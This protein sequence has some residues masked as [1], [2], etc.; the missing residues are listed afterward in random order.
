[1]TATSTSLLFIWVYRDPWTLAEKRRGGGGGGAASDMNGEEICS[2]NDFHLFYIHTFNWSHSF[3]SAAVGYCQAQVPFGLCPHRKHALWLVPWQKTCPLACALTENMPFGLCPDRKHA[4][5][6]VPWQ[7]TCPLAWALTENMPFG[8]GPDRKQ[9]VFC[10]CLGLWHNQPWRHQKGWLELMLGDEV[11]DGLTCFMSMSEK[12]LLLFVIFVVL[13][14]VNL[15]QTCCR[16][17]LYHCLNGVVSNCLKK[18][19]VRSCCSSI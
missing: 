8:L 6:L 7:K 12:R 17:T 5:W 4:L 10:Q 11:D 19:G 1:M 3:I 18:H 15:Q 16:I 14:A 13:I 2:F 9:S